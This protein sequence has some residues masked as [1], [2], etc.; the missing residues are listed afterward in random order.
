MHLINICQKQLFLSQLNRRI[1]EIFK[2]RLLGVIARNSHLNA[3]KC[4]LGI[5]HLK[6]KTQ[7]LNMQQRW[8]VTSIILAPTEDSLIES[9]YCPHSQ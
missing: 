7:L 2:N 9:P 5:G 4:Y 8:E 1:V 3:Y 6:K